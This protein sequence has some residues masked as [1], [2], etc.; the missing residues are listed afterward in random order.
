MTFWQSVLVGVVLFFVF[1]YV[2]ERGG[3][4]LG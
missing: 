1:I 2:V 3:R 4:G